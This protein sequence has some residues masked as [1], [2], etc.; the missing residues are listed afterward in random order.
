MHDAYVFIYKEISSEKYFDVFSLAD[1]RGDVS[2]EM[3]SE[4]LS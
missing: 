2:R 1:V 3:L 4:G